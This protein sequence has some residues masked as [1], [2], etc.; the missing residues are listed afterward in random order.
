MEGVNIKHRVGL[1]VL[2]RFLVVKVIFNRFLSKLSQW[3]TKTKKSMRR[4]HSM[5]K[6]NQQ[7][8]LHAQGNVS[9]QF[10]IACSLHL[11]G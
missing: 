6:V 3:A 7:K 4:S 1:N 11:T 5:I 10:V 2:K 8:W 9:G